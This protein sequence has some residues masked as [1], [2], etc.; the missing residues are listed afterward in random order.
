[1]CRKDLKQ[2]ITFSNNCIMFSILLKFG[3][4]CIIAHRRHQISMTS[5]AKTSAAALNFQMPVQRMWL[6]VAPVSY[7]SLHGHSLHTSTFQSACLTLFLCHRERG[8]CCHLLGSIAQGLLCHNIRYG[9]LKHHLNILSFTYAHLQGKKDNMTT[10]KL[11]RT[12]TF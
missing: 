7:V 6:H 9:F 4:H 3:T 12:K 5:V 1:M 2:L 8:E 10:Q 11:C